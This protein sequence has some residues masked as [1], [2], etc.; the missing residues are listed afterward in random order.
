[1]EK[2]PEQT[3]FT[4]KPQDFKHNWVTHIWPYSQYS[5]WT[6]KQNMRNV[7]YNCKTP[8]NRKNSSSQ[9][10]LT[11][12]GL[13]KIHRVCSLHIWLR[14]LA[15]TRLSKN[16]NTELE[17]LYCTKKSHGLRSWTPSTGWVAALP[18]RSGSQRP[19]SRRITRGF[20]PVTWRSAASRPA[21]KRRVHESKARLRWLQRT[22]CKPSNYL[23]DLSIMHWIKWRGT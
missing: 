14:W 16:H 5:E 12:H 22:T 11:R 15:Q 21:R 8:T 4:N 23:F 20:S 7:R 9:L 18:R 3:T 10:I 17:R 6:S 1:M 13:H 19:W 2:P